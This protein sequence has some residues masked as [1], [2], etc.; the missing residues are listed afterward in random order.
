[1]HRLY[2]Q[3][4]FQFDAFWQLMRV[5]IIAAVQTAKQSFIGRF[6]VRSLFY[7][8]ILEIMWSVSFLRIKNPFYKVALEH[9]SKYLP[10]QKMIR[11]NAEVFL[12]QRELPKFMRL[13]L[14]VR[15]RVWKN[16]VCRLKVLINIRIPHLVFPRLHLL[17]AVD[18]FWENDKNLFINLQ[19]N[20]S[21]PWK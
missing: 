11:K 9:S 13:K 5:L 16:W 1:M 8:W 12:W 15:F 14:K 17:G 19:Q 6:L 7:D 2:F 21:S 10:L 4:T 20:S 18:F 3:N